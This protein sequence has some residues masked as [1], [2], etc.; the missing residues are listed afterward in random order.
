[1]AQFFLTTGKLQKGRYTT[2]KPV[3]ELSFILTN[4]VFKQS[5]QANIGI[6]PLF[7]AACVGPTPNLVTYG[8]KVTLEFSRPG[9]PTDN[10]LIESCNGSLGDECLNVHWFRDLADARHK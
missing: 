2:V 7:T 3:L 10:A 9:K 4:S 8:N 5:I 1:M 6:K